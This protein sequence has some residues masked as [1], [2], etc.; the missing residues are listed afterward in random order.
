MGHL[1]QGHG[2]CR[3]AG[4]QLDEA[5]LLPSM[6]PFNKGHMDCDNRAGIDYGSFAGMLQLWCAQLVPPRQR[7]GRS[8]T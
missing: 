5:R 4:E 7:A 2:H 6:R 3:A 1:L 8:G